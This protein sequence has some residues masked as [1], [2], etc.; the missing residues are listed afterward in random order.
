MTKTILPILLIVM[1][2]A[3]GCS[4]QQ[5]PVDKAPPASV[6]IPASQ[7]ENSI[8]SETAQ[9]SSKSAESTGT[10]ELGLP[11]MTAENQSYYDKYL[12]PF[13]TAY[14]MFV[15]SFDENN[16]EFVAPARIY[17]CLA[18]P[19]EVKEVPQEEVEALI[20]QWFPMTSEQ[21]R[22]LSS[23]R[24]YDA[25]K[26]V[27]VPMPIDGA[28]PDTSCGVVT[29]SNLTDGILT[30]TCDWYQTSQ[31][32]QVGTYEKRATAITKIRIDSDEK[33]FYLSN[34]SDKK[35]QK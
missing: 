22:V 13:Y 18:K 25:Q 15:Y 23:I 32:G 8:S 34:A 21:V 31:P 9:S 6:S 17:S 24:E 19:T 26:Q 1:L 35:Y 29:D 12:M 2:V 14:P 30:L 3:I 11:K 5:K 28:T 10:E 33:W 16:W 4:N 7:S 27:Y 20:T